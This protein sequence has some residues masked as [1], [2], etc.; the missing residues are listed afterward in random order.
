M[1]PVV[2]T[3]IL[4][5]LGKQTI[6]QIAVSVGLSS[7][8]LR[9]YM[10]RTGL[11]Q[12]PNFVRAM[13]LRASAKGGMVFGERSRLPRNERLTK[14][15]RR[16]AA[17]PRSYHSE[18]RAKNKRWCVERMGGRCRCGYDRLGA[19]HIL[20]PDGRVFHSGSRCGWEKIR[21]EL[22]VCEVVCSNCLAEKRSR[23]VS[24]G[25]IESEKQNNPLQQ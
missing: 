19:L 18:L 3:R 13:R 21:R 4:S 14:Y 9:R 7:A 23:V 6:D 1:H 17:R 10:K 11:R 20:R 25:A 8:G 12:D 22:S 5:F 2:A 15:S 24:E 16:N